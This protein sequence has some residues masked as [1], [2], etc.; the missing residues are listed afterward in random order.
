[1]YIRSMKMKN[2]YFIRTKQQYYVHSVNQ[3]GKEI[4]SK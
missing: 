3:D 1:M 2:N 4:L